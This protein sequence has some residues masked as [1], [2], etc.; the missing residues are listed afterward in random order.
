M[1]SCHPQ[2][3]VTRCVWKAYAQRRD[4]HEVCQTVYN[5]ENLFEPKETSNMNRKWSKTFFS[6][7]C[8]SWRDRLGVELF[9]VTGL[10][11]K[12]EF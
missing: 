9:D 12:Q 6:Q 8:A 7:N 10:A 4:E 2:Y 3:A 1:T 5:F 11:L